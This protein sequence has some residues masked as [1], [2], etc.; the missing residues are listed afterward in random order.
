MEAY[1]T[2]YK[3]NMNA[4]VI[5]CCGSHCPEE[6]ITAELER[7][8]IAVIKLS[9]SDECYRNDAD[10][11]AVRIFETV[12]ALP[13]GMP[14]GYLGASAA[15]AGALIAAAEHPDLVAA[16]VSVNGRTD[17][18]IDQLRMVR[19]PTLLIVNDMPVLR[20]NREAL[21]LLRGERRLEIIHGTGPEATPAIVNKAA[22][23]LVDR[24]AVGALAV[25]Q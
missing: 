2:A 16:V 4:V 3:G 9:E 22:R 5:F 25:S 6:A 20:M 12:K 23:W 14:V 19:T 11:V 10:Y 15:A 24:V 21:S 8:D 7:N 13:A 1:G 18:A 17:L